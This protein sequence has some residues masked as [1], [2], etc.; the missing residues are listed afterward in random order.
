MFGGNP[1]KSKEYFEKAIKSYNRKFLMA[2]VLYAQT[3]AV[4]TQDPV[5]FDTLL[6]EV[7]AA[8]PE[9]LPEQRLANELAV[10]RAKW[11]LAN[12]DKFFDIEEQVT[13]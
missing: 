10:E 13:N 11:L 7:A 3:Y 4:Q 12:K 2:I 1:Q 9:A 5:L 8:N 6:N